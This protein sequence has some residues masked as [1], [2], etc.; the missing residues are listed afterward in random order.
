MVP[1]GAADDTWVSACVAALGPDTVRCELDAADRTALAGRLAGLAAGGTE[2][3][4]VLS[5]LAPDEERHTGFG[6]VPRGL[7][8]TLTLVQ[9]L[10]DAGLD[11]P[12]WCATRGAVSTGPDDGLTRP[13]Q[14]ALWGLGRVVALEHPDRWGGLVDLPGTVDARAA[15]RLTAVLAGL[16]GEDQVAIRP[17]GLYGRRLV[18]ATPTAGAPPAAGRAAARH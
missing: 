11:A 18:H 8:L 9:A 1:A 16:D 10:G 6:S 17:S 2:F 5:L 12:L 13:V 14:G 15:A 4:G 3:A 7:A